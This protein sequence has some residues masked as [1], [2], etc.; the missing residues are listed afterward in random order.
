MTEVENCIKGDNAS[1]ECGPCHWNSLKKLNE[2]DGGDNGEAD[3]ITYKT[4]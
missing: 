3:D 2:I 4:M 1:S